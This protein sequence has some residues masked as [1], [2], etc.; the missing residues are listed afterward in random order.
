MS[1]VE[2]PA[3]PHGFEALAE[4]ALDFAGGQVK[5][6]VTTQPDAFPIYT[7]GRPLAR[8]GRG[9]DQLDRGLPRRSDVDPR[10]P[11]G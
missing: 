2:T 5:R 1:P 8:R 11:D 4:E 9:V 7:V 6:L 3:L 10:P